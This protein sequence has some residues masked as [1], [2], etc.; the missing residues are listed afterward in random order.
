MKAALS[1]QINKSDRNDARGIAQMMRVGLYRPVL[2]PNATHEPSWSARLKSKMG[3]HVSEV[4]HGRRRQMAP[5]P[6]VNSART[7]SLCDDVQAAAR[8]FELML[9]HQHND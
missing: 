6:M 1:A 7:F 8:E 9:C 5:S 3:S 4:P 2:V